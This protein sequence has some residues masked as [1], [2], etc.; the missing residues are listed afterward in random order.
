MTG[1]AALG[2]CGGPAFGQGTALRPGS[3]EDLIAAAQLGGEVS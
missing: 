1:L 3:A 2:L